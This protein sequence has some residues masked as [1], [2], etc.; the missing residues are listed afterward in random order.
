MRRRLG[1]KSHALDAVG[2][3]EG[4]REHESDEPGQRQ[5][6]RENSPP[7]VEKDGD[8]HEYS[9]VGHLAGNHS[10][11][12]AEIGSFPE[13]LAADLASG[14][15]HD[16]ADDQV[17]EGEEPVQGPQVDVLVSMPAPPWLPRGEPG[18]G[19]LRYVAVDSIDVGRTVMKDVV[20]ELPEPRARSEAIGDVGQQTIHAGIAE[21]GPV[22]GVVHDAGRHANQ[23]QEQHAGRN[24]ADQE[25]PVPDDQAPVAE[26]HQHQDEHRLEVEPASSSAD[27]SSRRESGSPELHQRLVR[28][29]LCV[30]LQRDLLES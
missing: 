30:D 15:V 23:S 4:D 14:E 28:G 9:E 19:S 25:P 1:L 13:R 6:E 11:D 17:L 21:E 16:V 27:L 29:V 18:E 24:H 22:V 26:D 10:G 20:F 7:G 5:V 3:L 2:Q 8:D 12:R